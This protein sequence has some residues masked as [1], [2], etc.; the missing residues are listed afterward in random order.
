MMESKPTGMGSVSFHSFHETMHVSPLILC[1][2]FC[3][4]I[5]CDQSAPQLIVFFITSQHTMYMCKLTLPS[6]PILLHTL[7]FNLLISFTG[8]NVHFF[9]HVLTL[10]VLF[11]VNTLTLALHELLVCWQLKV[12][13]TT[14]LAR[15]YTL[16]CLFVGVSHDDKQLIAMQMLLSLSRGW[17]PSSP[18]PLPP[19]SLPSLCCSLCC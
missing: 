14:L 4:S 2:I 1:H 5:L 8:I 13:N 10:Y 16:P 19:S 3:V 9:S 6:P 17:S 15:Q 11:T 12:I 18:P 7:H